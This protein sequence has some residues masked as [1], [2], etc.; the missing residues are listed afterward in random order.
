MSKS[1]KIRHV[2]KSLINSLEKSMGVVTNACK[3]VG[4]HRS[5]FYEYYNNDPEFKKEV[6][7]IGNVALDFTESK[8]FEQ[9]RDG[10]TS[11]IKFYLATKGKKRGYVERQE[12][13]GSDG[14][15]LF[16]IKIIDTRKDEEQS[17]DI[18]E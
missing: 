5:T 2:K 4:I 9:I 17:G 3:N 12:I 10:N 18:N 13:T 1:D 8:M 6:N 11:L 14:E 15:K 7:D 16:E